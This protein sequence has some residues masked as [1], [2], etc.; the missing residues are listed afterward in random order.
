MAHARLTRNIT[1][2]EELQHAWLVVIIAS[3]T[4]NRLDGY[5]QSLGRLLTVI[6][7]DGAKTQGEIAL[8]RLPPDGLGGLQLPLLFLSKDP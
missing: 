2:E 5:F 7:T 1:L 3:E 4:I 6:A 8:S